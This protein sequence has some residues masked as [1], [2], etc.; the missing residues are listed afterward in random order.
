MGHKQSRIPVLRAVGIILHQ[1][2]RLSLKTMFLSRG[3]YGREGG[4]RLRA[5]QLSRLDCGLFDGGA[6]RG[7]EVDYLD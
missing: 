3:K 7:R 2:D 6:R 4:D 1:P 5:Q